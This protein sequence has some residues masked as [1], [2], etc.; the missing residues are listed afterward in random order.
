MIIC[1]C[2]VQHTIENIRVF[3]S[4]SFSSS[5]PSE[6]IIS[7]MTDLSTQN[8]LF[9]FKKILMY[10]ILTFLISPI[11]DYYDT[12][13]N[14][15]RV[16]AYFCGFPEFMKFNEYIIACGNHSYQFWAILMVE[17]F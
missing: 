12:I 16:T 2:Q 4:S 9:A 14:E 1:F 3:Y 6:V 15:D 17:C 11:E 8:L 10:R 13:D 7:S 5:F